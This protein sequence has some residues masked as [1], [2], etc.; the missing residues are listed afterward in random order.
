MPTKQQK[1]Y[2]LE[3]VINFNS[4]EEC[5]QI[6]HNNEKKDQNWQNMCIYYDKTIKGKVT[7]KRLITT[8]T[9]DTIPL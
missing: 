7:L 9:K 1:I 5:D 8:Y 2:N 3:R 4:A 6:L